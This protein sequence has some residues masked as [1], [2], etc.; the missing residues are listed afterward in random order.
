MGRTYI[1]LGPPSQKS[2]YHDSQDLRPM[3]VWFYSNGHAALPP[4][5]Y[6]VFYRED[7]FSEYK[8]YSPYFD[9]LEKLVKQRAETLLQSCQ[10]IDYSG[11]QE[12]ARLAVILIH[13]KLV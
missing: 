6:I 7:N 2:N 9:V 13:G 8:L 5:F 12:L 4:F 11:G 1:V 10:K 3:E